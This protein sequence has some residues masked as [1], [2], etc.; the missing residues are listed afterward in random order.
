MPSLQCPDCG[1]RHALD[2]LGDAAAFRCRGCERVLKVPERFRTTPSGAGVA[3]AAPGAGAGAIAGTGAGAASGA[4]SAVTS[5]G[6]RADGG[7]LRGAE[8]GTGTRAR[9][10]ERAKAVPGEAARDRGAGAVTVSA[11]LRLLIWVVSIPL[12]AVLVFGV[13]E[14]LG[15]LT[16]RQ[17]IDT[18]LESGMDRFGAVARLLPFWAL[19]SA[20]L[21]HLAVLGLGRR[22]ASRAARPDGADDPRGQR[23]DERSPARA[24]S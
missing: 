7:A 22:R 13:A 3:N 4:G 24:G 14:T 5:S 2:G 9:R 21:V 15:V 16:S 17:L 19:V 6:A 18:F 11:W 23:R 10:R 8:T 20:A 1:E 12:G